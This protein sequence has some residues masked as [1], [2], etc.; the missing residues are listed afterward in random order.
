MAFLIPELADTPPI[1]IWLIPVSLQLILICPSRFRQWYIVEAHISF[2]F[3]TI[4]SGFS[5]FSFV[6]KNMAVF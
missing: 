4:K 5:N 3:S 6:Q 2:M 1:A